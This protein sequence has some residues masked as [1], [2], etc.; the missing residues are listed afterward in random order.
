MRALL[1][2]ALLVIAAGCFSKPERAEG[3]TDAAPGDA[4]PGDGA[5]P[6]DAPAASVCTPSRCPGTCSGD[7]FCELEGSNSDDPQQ[8]PPDLK[9]RIRCAQGKCKGGVDCGTASACDVHCTG[10]DACKDGRID[11]G[12]AAVCTVECE[13]DNACQ[14]SSFPAVDC[15]GSMCT[16]ECD[17]KAACQ[18]GVRSSGGT[19]TAAC[20][21]D[22]ATCQ[23]SDDSCSRTMQCD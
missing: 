8:C 18:K 9:C 5:L 15:G 10:K 2:N 21:G 20:C 3:T 1:L 6:V 11:C 19:C 23:D 13:G 17:G 4:A 16:V 12:T 14:G 22:S 7:G